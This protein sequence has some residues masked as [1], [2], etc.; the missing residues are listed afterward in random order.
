MYWNHC[1]EIICW[2]NHTV[3]SWV[4]I[5]DYD[6]MSDFMLW[7]KFQK[8]WNRIYE[9]HFWARAVPV[10]MRFRQVQG[11][12]S[13]RLYNEFKLCSTWAGAAPCCWAGCWAV[14]ALCTTLL[15]S[16]EPPGSRA[17]PCC[18][19]VRHRLL[20]RRSCDSSCWDGAPSSASVGAA[21]LARRWSRMRSWTTTWSA[22]VPSCGSVGT[23]ATAT[24]PRHFGSLEDVECMQ[25][26]KP[27]TMAS[28]ICVHSFLGCPLIAEGLSWKSPA[29]KKNDK[30]RNNNWS[31]MQHANR[32]RCVI[33]QARHHRWSRMDDWAAMLDFPAEIQSNK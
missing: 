5:H 12:I 30:Q 11:S 3:I 24:S 18:L 10:P 6:F 26:P 20:S 31:L 23:A 19:T 33:Q 32:S 4:W 1:Y 9:T 27:R 15:L 14:R 2:W 16:D 21:A 7:N 28:L 8:S 17:S 22:G 25:R 29:N 13:L